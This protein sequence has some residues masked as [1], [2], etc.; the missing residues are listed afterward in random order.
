MDDEDFGTEFIIVPVPDPQ[1]MSWDMMY[2]PF[3]APT[4]RPCQDP[5]CDCG[6]ENEEMALVYDCSIN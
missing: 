3:S 5:D 2:P 6:G 1:E 4:G